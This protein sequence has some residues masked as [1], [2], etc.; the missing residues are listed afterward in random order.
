MVE[1]HN[2][3]HELAEGSIEIGHHLCMGKDDIYERINV[4]L[5]A[6]SDLVTKNA[7]L[8]SLEGGA[9]CTAQTALR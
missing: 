6:L 8:H 1:F 9:R 3:V 4:S 7:V 2:S 5:K